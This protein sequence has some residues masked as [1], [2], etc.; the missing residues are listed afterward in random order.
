MNLS[1]HPLVR[2]LIFT[3][4]LFRHPLDSMYELRYRQRGS[5]L[6]ASL[7]LLILYA[8]MVFDIGVTNFQFNLLGLRNTT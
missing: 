6:S 2:Q 8:V 3:V 1:R 4:R 7:I 5:V